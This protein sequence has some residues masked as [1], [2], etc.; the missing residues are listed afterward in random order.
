MVNA[1]QL[2]LRATKKNG[3]SLEMPDPVK[4]LSSSLTAAVPQLQWK[5]SDCTDIN[6]I[7]YYRKTENSP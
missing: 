4:L 3:L 7:A 5:L 6:Y 2:D 1:T